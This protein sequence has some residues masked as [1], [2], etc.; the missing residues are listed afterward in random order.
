MGAKPK[1]E[2]II[3]DFDGVIVE[4]NSI[5]EKGF[6]AVLATYPDDEVEA[7]L[8]FHRENGGLSRYVKFHY[9]FEEVRM[10]NVNDKTI[11][12]YAEKFSRIMK[13][14]MTN[15]EILIEETVSFIKSNVEKYN[16]HIASGSDQEELRFL[17]A[18]LGI[19][20]NFIS[21]HGS[22]KPKNEIVKDLLKAMGYDLSKTLLIG[23]A[24]NDYEAARANN[25]YFMAYNTN[26]ILMA[27][28]N[29]ELKLSN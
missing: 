17:C 19:A 16:F 26:S 5:R 25:I 21:I 20:D 7:L 4:S 23:D 6:R 8:E 2:N 22:P 11:K 1:I 18:E 28:S 9:F 3:W 13:E 24:I 27:K 14:L 12:I 29:L 15:K 10:E